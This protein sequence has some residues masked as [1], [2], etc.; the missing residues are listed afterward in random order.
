MSCDSI[1]GPSTESIMSVKLDYL[2]TSLTF[3]LH[4]CS[5]AG[6]QLQKA[7]QELKL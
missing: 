1:L 2:H 4:S 5:S 3:S 6:K 7:S